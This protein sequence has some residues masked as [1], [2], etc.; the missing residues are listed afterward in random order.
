MSEL[1]PSTD[2]PPPPPKCDFR[3]SRAIPDRDRTPLSALTGAYS[4]LGSKHPEFNQS[5]N[6]T[7]I[8]EPNYGDSA[9]LHRNSH[10]KVQHG[11]E[12]MRLRGLTGVRDE[13]HLAAI[14]P[15]P[16]HNGAASSRPANEGACAAIA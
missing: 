2:P 7:P 12:R 6:D 11:F 16:Q 4:L 1:G 3:Y 5:P 10:L 14:V 15:E 9:G 8:K 13:F